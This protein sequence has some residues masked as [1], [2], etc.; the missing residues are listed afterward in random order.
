ME[1]KIC[2]QCQIN[3]SIN[4]EDIAL[5]TKISP[6]TN[7]KKFPIPLP[8]LC[9]Q[10]REQ[11]RLVWRNERKLY[12]RKC[13]LC[14]KEMVSI[15]SPD[16]DYKVCCAKCFWSD[17][18]DP[19]NIGQNYDF[20][21]SFFKQFNQLLHESKLLS[22][23]STNNENSDFTN[24][25]S[26]SKNCYLNVGGHYNENCYYNTYS[27]NGKNNI[28]N[29]WI[30]YCE[31][32]Y[33]SVNCA[34]CNN[35]SYLNDCAGCDNCHFCQDCLEC[36][37]CFASANLSHK[38]Y[39]FFNQPLSKD[40]YFEKVNEYMSNYSGIKKSILESKNHLKKF[41]YKFADLIFCENCT[42]DHLKN[43]R[44]VSHGFYF[45]KS[46]NCK[47][48]SIGYELKDSMDINSLG[49]SELNYQICSAFQIPRSIF[50]AHLVAS[51]DCLYS[52]ANF[53]SQN[54]FGCVG[55]NHKQYCIL[56]KQYSKEEYEKLVPQIINHM[57]KT[58][59]WGQFFPMNISP[60]GYNET[61][62]ME[63]YPLTKDHAKKI[64]AKWL[65][66]DFG[67][68][69]NGPF[70][71]P[72]DIS[73][74]NPQSNPKAQTEIDNCLKGILKCEITDRPFK[75]LP[76]ELAQY[77]E[78]NIQIPRRHPD[79]RHIDRLAKLNPRK[80][81]HRQCMCE[82]KLTINNEQLTRKSECQHQGRCTNEFETTY[83]PERTEKVYCENCYQK[84]VL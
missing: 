67:I 8:S 78:R 61:V 6:E 32:L 44:N 30:S 73:I 75:I 20:D 45:D 35:S 54:L 66:E 11:Q 14:Q 25:E 28:D 17:Q 29:Y 27:L 40:K 62:A 58:N 48:I 81:W 33:N 49:W 70:Y 19:I 80:L 5:L 63:Y 36:K 15:Y 18:W 31:N 39:Y 12:K 37:N 60:F 26:E 51:Q 71:E 34:K 3:F 79:Q 4:N 84:S 76:Q 59:E 82:E 69:Y 21:Q 56:N 13:H 53:N 9:P 41:R 65:D 74:Y 10:C 1:S 38:E 42:G 46:D 52:F 72:K 23:V 68:K 16:K 77:I 43:C 22:L 55:L 47:N 83:A 57:E 2:S 7:G 24:H 64:N 50:C